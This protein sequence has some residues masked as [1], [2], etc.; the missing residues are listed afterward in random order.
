MHL[1]THVPA[2]DPYVLYPHYRELYSGSKENDNVLYRMAYPSSVYPVLNLGYPIFDNLGNK[3]EPGHYEVA[4]SNDK[5][6]LLLI[7]SKQLIAKIPVIKFDFNQQ[8]Y[9]ENH[10]K[11]EKLQA[12]LEKYQIKRNRKRIKQYKQ[13]IEYLDK[14]IMAKN[15]AEIDNSNPE[16]FILDYRCNF[17]TATGFIKRASQD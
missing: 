13:E 5:K 7:Q 2:N 3:L 15:K 9:D 6:Y 14:K 4:L 16:Y 11:Y 1:D 8:E 12:L 10:E 17:A